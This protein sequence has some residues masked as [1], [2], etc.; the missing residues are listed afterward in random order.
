MKKS[1]VTLSLALFAGLAGNVALASTGSVSFV[2]SI[3]PVTC[4]IEVIDPIGI[5]PGNRVSMG[6][7]PLGQFTAVGTEVG[8]APFS[9][10]IPSKS[11]AGAM[12]NATVQF[13][14][15]ADGNYF[16]VN[17]VAGAAKNVAIALKDNNNVP[18][19]P[20]VVSPSY[21]LN[22]TGPTDLKF[23]A[24][25]RS[26]AAGVTAGLASAKVQFTVDYL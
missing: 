3:T 22:D 21:K 25:Y 26:T 23:T 11:C 24:Y 15:D 18:I 19:R 7:F 6:D 4:N 1:L 2:G 9:I 17:P 13:D 10:R 16:R 8:G 20:G 5:G 14:G 12:E